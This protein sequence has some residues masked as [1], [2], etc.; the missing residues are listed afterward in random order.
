VVSSTPRPH[1]NPGKDPVPILQEA[2]WAPG[3]V[4]TGGNSRPHRYSIPDRVARSQSL[5][6]LSYP[7]HMCVYIHICIYSILILFDNCNFSLHAAIPRRVCGRETEWARLKEAWVGLGAG[8]KGV[9]GRYL[10]SLLNKEA[11]SSQ[12]SRVTNFCLQYMI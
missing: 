7:I 3:S 4:R 6:R 2:G 5:Y 10:L 8:L 1:F 11:P 9:E 12:A